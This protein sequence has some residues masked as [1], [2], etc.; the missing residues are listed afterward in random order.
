MLFD[1][2]LYPQTNFLILFFFLVLVVLLV[3]QYKTLKKR[4]WLLPI[5]LLLLLLGFELKLYD[6]SEKESKNLYLDTS[7]SMSF[8]NKGLLKQ[9]VEKLSDKFDLNQ[10]PFNYKDEEI[11]NLDFNPHGRIEQIDAKNAI[12]ISDLSNQKAATNI[13]KLPLEKPSSGIFNIKIPGV[14]YIREL[15]KIS[16]DVYSKARQ[17]LIL[18]IK[19]KIVKRKL[20]LP[21]TQKRHTFAFYANYAPKNYRASIELKDRKVDAIIAIQKGLPSG[22]FYTER[23]TILS[24]RLS[25]LIKK[26][27]FWKVSFGSQKALLNSKQYDFKIALL[28]E[29]MPFTTGSTLQIIQKSKV[30]LNGYNKKGNL[31]SK[32]RAHAFLWEVNPQKGNI[33]FDVSSL[34]QALYQ[35]SKT[36]KTE[37]VHFEGVYPE[38]GKP[39]RLTKPTEFA[40]RFQKLNIRKNYDPINLQYYYELPYIGEYQFQNLQF[41]AGYQL[42]ELNSLW[43]MKSKRNFDLDTAISK[44]S[45]SQRSLNELES[46][47]IFFGFDQSI[48]PGKLNI[49]VWLFI[50][51]L[52]VSLCLFWYLPNDA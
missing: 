18:K 35:F 15:C 11:T 3:L 4:I 46:K 45:Y 13:L 12:I 25:Y 30:N 36:L 40:L 41:S 27:P 34:E 5:L 51:S 10:T 21:N 2:N 26:F 9:A 29:P 24:W 14:C 44:I 8:V 32:D 7:Y 37:R 49:F 43:Q 19:D 52:I 31:Y 1:F 47:K 17:D 48:L 6:N 20:I 38:V 28:N 33:F 23:P 42:E 16:V 50:I 22:Y 39:L